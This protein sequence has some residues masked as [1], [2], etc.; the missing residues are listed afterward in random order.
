M[1]EPED[2]PCVVT[3]EWADSAGN[4]AGRRH[5]FFPP[6]PC[7]PQ[8]HLLRS[9]DSHIPPL[10]VLIVGNNEQHPLLIVSHPF[11]IVL[12]PH[13]ARSIPIPH[14]QTRQHSVLSLQ[15]LSSSPHALCLTHKPTLSPT[16]TVVQPG[17]LYFIPQA[18]VPRRAS[19]H[20]RRLYQQVPP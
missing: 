4:S 3:C 10:L 1:A 18:P 12:I 15:R 8:Q 17:F 9:A 13:T 5:L 2:G 7:L 20:G 11:F 16:I 19:S 14:H 6:I